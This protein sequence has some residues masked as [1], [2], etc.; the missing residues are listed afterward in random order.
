MLNE[1]DIKALARQTLY[2]SKKRSTPEGCQLRLLLLF[3]QRAK[4]DVRPKE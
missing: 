4:G 3:A 1:W 2:T